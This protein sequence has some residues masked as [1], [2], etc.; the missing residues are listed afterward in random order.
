MV[1]E[2]M[3]KIINEM[4][5]MPSQNVHSGFHLQDCVYNYYKHNLGRWNPYLMEAVPKFLSSANECMVM[6]NSYIYWKFLQDKVIS[7]W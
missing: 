7:N 4:S 2:G 1:S 3:E 6:V 5:V